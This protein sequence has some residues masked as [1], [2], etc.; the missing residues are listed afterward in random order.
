MTNRDWDEL[1]RQTSPSWYLDPIVARQKRDVH[2]ELI[3]GW[4]TATGDESV[5]KTDL[6]EEAF[7]ADRILQDLL[8][9]SRFVCG[10]DTAESTARAAAERGLEGR[11]AACDVRRMPFRR[12]AFHVVI[13]TSTLDHF[14]TRE[15]FVLSLREI[16]RV[17][18]PGG[19]LILTL[20]NPLNPLYPVLRLLSQSRLTPYLLGYTPTPETLARMLR[21]VGFEVQEEE[22]LLHNPRLISTALFLCCRK[23]FGRYADR[24]VLWMLSAFALL[25]KLPTRRWTACFQAV[26]ARRGVSGGGVAGRGE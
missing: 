17:M 25:G 26:A 2:L 19:L 23:L 13:S 5:L 22:W 10:I 15:E 24:P 9:E 14:E 11:T 7:G 21:E 4:W 6:F 12:D 20:D 1:G 3:R 8:P 16:H 18:R